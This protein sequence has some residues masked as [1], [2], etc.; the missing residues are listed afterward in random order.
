MRPLPRTSAP[1]TGAAGWAPWCSTSACCGPSARLAAIGLLVALAAYLGDNYRA[2]VSERNART[3]WG[4]LNEPAGFNIAFDTQFSPGQPV[5]DALVGR[6]RQHRGVR[7]GRH[8]DRHDHRRGR[9][10]RAPVAAAGS[11]ARRRRSTSRSSATSRCC[12]SSCSWPPGCSTLPPIDDARTFGDVLVISNRAIA[13]MSPE[14]G[15]NFGLYLGVLA[16]G[17][18]AAVAVGGVAHPGVRPPPGAPDRRY[19][20]PAG[21]SWPWPWSATSCWARRSRVPPRGRGPR[22]G[23]RCHLNIP[24]VAI[25]LALAIYHGSHIAEIVRGSDPGR[26][27]RAD[28]GGDR[29]RPE[30]DPA[31]ALRGPPP[32]VPHRGAADDQPVPQPHQEHLAR[33]RRRLLRRG[34]AVLPAHRH[35]RAPALQIGR[36]C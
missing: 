32:G 9:R 29:H 36:S 16:L 10:R 7:G 5:K 4:F 2:N 20:G 21:W 3:G 13:V 24:Y 12:S 27:P 34:R 14:A 11:P 25:T 6:H 22:H 17:V 30:R 33:H 8:R 26:A 23:R 28:R 15:D 19:C 31:P 18:V 1:R 35:A